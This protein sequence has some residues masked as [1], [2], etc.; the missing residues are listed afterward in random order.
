MKKTFVQV[1]VVIKGMTVKKTNVRGKGG[2]K[3]GHL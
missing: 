1:V 2:F 3:V